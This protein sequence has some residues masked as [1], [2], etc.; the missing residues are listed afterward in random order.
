MSTL[1]VVLVIMIGYVLGS[2]PTAYIVARSR[3]VNIFQVGS[4]NMGANNVMRSCGTRYGALVWLVDGLKGVLAVWLGRVLVPDHQAA[5]SVIGALSVVA[6]HN[7][8]F[9]ASLI[10]GGI[11][12]GKGAATASGTFILLAPTLVVALI[13]ALGT[14]IVLL[15]RYVSLGVLISVAAAGTAIM[16]L[17]IFG[18]RE[19]VYTGYLLVCWLVFVRHRKN[20][21]AL[22]KGTE[23]RLGERV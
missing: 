5:A 20:I 11:R 8:S 10:A 4:G 23:R 9:I 1:S 15:T 22:I 21:V 3:G 14:V 2:F 16:L 18:L 6:G 7:W 12:G 19:P 17:V 13:L